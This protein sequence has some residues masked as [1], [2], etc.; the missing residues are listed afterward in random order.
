MLPRMEAGEPVDPGLWDAREEDPSGGAPTPPAAPA[1]GWVR[2]TPAS[3][4]PPAA[5]APQPRQQQPSPPAGSSRAGRIALGVLVAVAAVGGGTAVGATVGGGD[6]DAAVDAERAPVTRDVE[7]PTTTAETPSALDDLEGAR[8]VG[9]FL[10][11][12][13]VP[14]NQVVV[15]VTPAGIVLELHL[16]LPDT[17]GCLYFDLDAGEPIEVTA[18]EAAIV[19]NGEI[20]ITGGV[21]GR[22]CDEG[23]PD[24]A[25]PVPA[26]LFVTVQEDVGVDGTLTL[27][28]TEL[29]FTAREG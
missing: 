16:H 27:S 17:S 4:L 9:S 13:G 29:R 21:A 7:G 12:A 26:D 19:A 25:G 28:T 2:V 23:G 6:D 1:A 22:A 15:E 20:S 8:F 3:P 18:T 10:A 11:D 14:V 5:W 24:E